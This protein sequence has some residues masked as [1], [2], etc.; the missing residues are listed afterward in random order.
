[1]SYCAQSIRTLTGLVG[2]GKGSEENTRSQ[3]VLRRSTIVSVLA[4]KILLFVCPFN[5][6]L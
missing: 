6:S 2:F 3:T 4:S 1:M 5:H